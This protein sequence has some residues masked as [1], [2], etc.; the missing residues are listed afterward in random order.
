MKHTTETQ[1]RDSVH[2]P[3]LQALLL[4]NPHSFVPVLQLSTAHPQHSTSASGLNSHPHCALTSPGSQ[5]AHGPTACAQHSER[6]EM[7]CSLSSFRRGGGWG[8]SFSARDR[9]VLIR[10]LQPL[11]LQPS[12]RGGSSPVGVMQPPAIPAIP[13]K[14]ELYVHNPPG[15]APVSCSTHRTRTQ[16]QCWRTTPLVSPAWC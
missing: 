16:Q 8:R 2:S 12:V 7:D 4:S 13:H 6:E 3:T 14:P 15:P 9:R 5:R 10:E 11:S 1:T